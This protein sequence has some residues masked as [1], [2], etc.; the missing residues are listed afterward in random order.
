MA[1]LY[2]EVGVCKAGYRTSVQFTLS[3][4]KSKLEDKVLT[5][6]VNESTRAAWLVNHVSS[7]EQRVKPGEEHR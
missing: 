4:K 6:S 5:K 3:I 1:K 2:H 7:D